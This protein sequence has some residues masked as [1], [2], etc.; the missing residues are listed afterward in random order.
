MEAVEDISSKVAATVS[1][2]E[3]QKKAQRQALA[4]GPITFFLTRLQERLEAGGGQ[5]FAGGR[6]SVAD[7][8]VFVWVRHLR[9]GKLDYIPADLPDR[10]AVKLVAHFERLKNHPGVK[11][12]YAKHGVAE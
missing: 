12:Y 11:A 4:A 2:P 8:K 6:L 7:L 10:V 9:S 3:D 5:Y 1:L